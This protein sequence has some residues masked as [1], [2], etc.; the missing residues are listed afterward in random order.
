MVRSAAGIGYGL[1][2]ASG[3]SS[4]NRLCWKRERESAIA[5]FSRYELGFYVEIVLHCEKC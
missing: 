4:L 2:S 3:V 5:S 1:G